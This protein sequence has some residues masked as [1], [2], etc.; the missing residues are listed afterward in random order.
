MRDNINISFEGHDHG[1]QRVLKVGMDIIF[2]TR[3][4]YV[5]TSVMPHTRPQ[6]S[7]LPCKKVN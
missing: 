5:P 3:L 2:E 6:V 1:P 7:L 4:A